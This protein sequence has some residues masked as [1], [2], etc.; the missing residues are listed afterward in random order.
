MFARIVR[1]EVYAVLRKWLERRRELK[2]YLKEL[3]AEA[4]QSGAPLLRTMFW[5]FPADPRAW[6][7]E[8][9]YMFGSRYLVAPVLEAGAR[10]R[11]LWLPAGRWKLLSTGEVY[12]SGTVTVPAPLEEMP[13]FEKLL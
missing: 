11:A 12:E 3:Y 8:D 4:S 13:V 5:E 1:L 7:I 6:E 10:S 9:Q 2:P